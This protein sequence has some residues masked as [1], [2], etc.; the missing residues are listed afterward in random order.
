MRRLFGLLRVFAN[1]RD[2]NTA[3]IFGFTLFP[4][5][6]LTGAAVDFSHGNAAKA[7]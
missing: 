7:S 1:A 2:G 4:L 3:I 6:L 5:L